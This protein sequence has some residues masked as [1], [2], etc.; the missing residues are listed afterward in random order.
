MPL[1]INYNEQSLTTLDEK[2]NYK[3]QAPPYLRILSTQD[4]KIGKMGMHDF[5]NSFLLLKWMQSN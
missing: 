3:S 2:Q 4:A 5:I 1:P